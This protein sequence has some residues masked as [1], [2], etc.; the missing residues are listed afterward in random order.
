MLR[1]A[2]FRSL[3]HCSTL[4]LLSRFS[5]RVHFPFQ[6]H[7]LD[8]PSILELNIKLRELLTNREQVAEQ[9]FD[10][11]KVCDRVW[12]FFYIYRMKSDPNLQPILLVPTKQFE[13]F[14]K[15]INHTL[16]TNLTIP[17]DGESRVT[18]FEVRFPTNSTPR[19]RYLGR[20]ITQAKADE[21]KS[22][23]PPSYFKAPGEV[24]TEKN[25]SDRDIVTFESTVRIIT[26]AQRAKRAA[27]KE[28]TRKEQIQIRSS[29]KK[30]IKRTQRY[31]GFREG[32]PGLHEASKGGDLENL[33]W[34][35][36]ADA[37]K[38]AATKIP[39]PAFKS[40]KPAPFTQEKEVVFIAVDVEAYERNHN[41]ITEIGIATLDTADIATVIPGEGGKNWLSLIR[42]RHFRIKEHKSYV[43]ADFVRGC[44]DSFEFGESEFIGLKDAPKAIADCFKHPFSGPADELTTDE[45]PTRNIVLVGHDLGADVEYLRK[46]GYDITNLANLRDHVDT[47]KMW[48]WVTMN[49]QPASL[50]RILTEFDLPHWNP[51]NAGNDAVYTLQAMIFIAI[52][53]LIDDTKKKEA[54]LKKAETRVTEV[55]TSIPEATIKHREDWSSTGDGSDGGAPIKPMTTTSKKVDIQKRIDPWNLDGDGGWAKPTPTNPPTSSAPRRGRRRSPSPSYPQDRSRGLNTN[56]SAA[57]WGSYAA[58]ALNNA[59]D[60]KYHQTK[61]D[62]WERP[63]ETSKSKKNIGTY[64]MGNKL[65]T[66]TRSGPSNVQQGPSRCI[67]NAWGQEETV[68]DDT[69]SN[70]PDSWSVPKFR[71]ND[72]HFPEMPTSNA[73]G[74]TPVMK[75][76]M[77]AD[78]G[79]AEHATNITHSHQHTTNT[80]PWGEP[81]PQSA[82][83]IR[84]AAKPVMN[85]W[86]EIIEEDTLAVASKPRA[87]TYANVASKGKRKG[88]AVA[89]KWDTSYAAPSFLLQ[90]SSRPARPA[91]KSGK[92]T[93]PRGNARAESETS[94]LIDLCSVAPTLEQVKR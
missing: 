56:A 45:L 51:H 42:P 7:L 31:L 29:W 40:D 72:S 91:K 28:K 35:T 57:A 9:F 2:V 11:G 48:Q 23:V 25:P 78:F 47:A 6:I 67:I 15:V 65:E 77:I 86:G 30:T 1:I 89:E 4:L 27:K 70:L 20:S 44:A 81:L 93:T 61:T 85:A 54:R 82:L 16:K 34:N 90:H 76:E 64:A 5:P 80:N 37:I 26:E 68:Y 59:R 14:L 79:R 22:N 18:A 24:M 69:N 63:Q 49:H 10:G 12:D 58:D 71:P 92:N 17:Y 13:H 38:E 87:P 83:P 43:N 50:V 84:S 33:T 32:T 19:P 75:N 46:I 21:L 53:H 66:C 3:C 88:K 73:W 39:P 41:I 94:D 52:K 74:Q 55:T 8:F 60:D 62:A 36:Y